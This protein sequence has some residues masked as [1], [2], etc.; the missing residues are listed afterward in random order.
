MEKTQVRLPVEQYG[1]WDSLL[2]PSLIPYAQLARVDKPGFLSIWIKMSIGLFEAASILRLP[3]ADVLPLVA[4]TAIMSQAIMWFN[5]AWNDT[6]DARV[7]REVPRTANRP[8]ARGALTMRQALIF[9]A[10]LAS[11]VGLLLLPVRS[12]CT[13]YSIPMTLGCLIYPLSK[14]FTNY[15][16]LVLGIVGPTGIYFGAAVAGLD[17][18]PY[19]SQWSDLLDMSSWHWPQSPGVGTLHISYITVVVWNIL[20]ETIYSYQDADWDAQAGVGTITRT[21][22]DRKTAKVFLVLLGLAQTILHF[23]NGFMYQPLPYP[24]GWLCSV[25]ACALSLSTQIE[26]VDLSR[27]E[28]CMFWFKNGIILTG[29]SLLLGSLTRYYTSV[30]AEL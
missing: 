18:I 15:P 8:L 1:I 5:F 10:I 28:S 26:S 21:L 23:I 16:Q 7:D 30:N 27:P 19:P 22:G 2:P 24:F 9:D 25:C 4:Y 3:I 11:I 14:R 12:T 6:C 17:P 20:T 29:S 13:V